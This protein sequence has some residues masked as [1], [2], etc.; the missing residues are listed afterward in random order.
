[1]GD[2]DRVVIFRARGRFLL[3]GVFL[4]LFGL[5]GV[6]AGLDS[7]EWWVV[8]GGVMLGFLGVFAFRQAAR[9][10]P[11]VVIDSEGIESG[12]QGFRVGWE[13]VEE[14]QPHSRYAGRFV[15]QRMLLLRMHD[16]DSVV[17][18]APNRFAQAVGALDRKLGVRTAFIPLN[19]LSLRP[20]EVLDSVRRFY[21][22]PI[23]GDF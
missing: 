11:A 17:R 9:R 2:P 23:R 6:L 19:M 15:R 3:L 20:R 22:G 8:I 21:R 12:I 7:K 1:M 4:S 5:L 14:I 13:E 10:D 16:I 18:Q